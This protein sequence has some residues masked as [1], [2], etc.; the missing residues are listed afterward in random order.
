[1]THVLMI[2]HSYIVTLNRRMCRELALAGGSEV[3]VTVAAPSSFQGDLGP[4]GLERPP[5]EPYTLEAIPTRLSRIPHLFSYGRELK[6]LLRSRPWD[7]VHVWEEPYIYAGAQ[8]A[9]W[10]PANA[11][12]IYSSFQNQ[13]KRYPPPFNLFERYC[14]RRA[15]AWTAFGETVANNLKDRPGY[16]DRPWRTISVGVDLDVFQPDPTAKQRVLA[17]LGWSEPGSPIVGYLGRFVPQK[18]LSLLMRALDRLEPST[19]RALW[20]GGGPMEA[21]LREWASRHGDRVRIA[22]GVA[23]DAVPAHLNAMDMLAAPSQTT[24]AWRE[25][26]G[27]MLVEAMGVG[28]PLVASDSG[29]IP[30]VVADAGLVLPETDETAWTQGL[31]RLLASAEQRSE[32]RERGFARAREHFAWPV[33]AHQYLDFFMQVRGGASKRAAS[34]SIP[35]SG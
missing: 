20:V 21:E 11:T 9:S 10:T 6:R 27:R 24:P 31:Q 4:I 35:E 12:L 5:G 19:W 22:T 25:Q 28:V 7:V 8:I 13:P 32:L 1:M 34:R 18:G 29:E 23:H 3:N 26:F 2:G 30:Y 16:R 15:S 33:V 17:G 14:L